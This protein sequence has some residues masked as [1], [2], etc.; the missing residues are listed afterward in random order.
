MQLNCLWTCAAKIAFIA[1]VVN[2]GVGLMSP[3]Q[4]LAA[5]RQQTPSDYLVTPNEGALPSSNSPAVREKPSLSLFQLL[6]AGGWFMVPLGLLSLAVVALTVERALALRRRRL[7]PGPLIDGIGQMSQHEGGLDPRGA[8][9][10]CQ[11]YP[12][13]A[14]QVFRAVLSKVGRPHAELETS[15]RDT[16]QRSATRLHQPVGWLNLIA[17][18]APLVG[19]LGT[20]W[21]ITQAFYDTTQ[22]QIGDNR[23]EA[24]ASGIYMALVTTIFGLTI[25]IPAAVAAHFFEVKIVQ[26]H[27]EIEDMI[28][29]LLPQLERYEGQVRF[30]DSPPLRRDPRDPEAGGSSSGTRRTPTRPR[31]VE[32]RAPHPV[33]PRED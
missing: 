28:A 3:N 26:Q 9:R 22:M 15:L 7:L 6:V 32:A 29:S 5:N 16:S 2:A 10:L 33:P 17:A 23:A 27:C 4:S 19:L 20:V 13:A 1:I 31:A 8:Y 12:S 18:I 11:A 24:L 14:S 21:G 30:I 25:A